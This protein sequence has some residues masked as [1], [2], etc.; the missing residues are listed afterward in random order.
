MYKN[1]GNKH[2][3]GLGVEGIPKEAPQ[4]YSCHFNQGVHWGQNWITSTHQRPALTFVIEVRNG[5]CVLCKLCGLLI[6]AFEKGSLRVVTYRQILI[7]QAPCFNFILTLKSSTTK[8]NLI[9]LIACLKFFQLNL[10]GPPHLTGGFGQHVCLQDR[11]PQPPALHRTAM[12][13]RVHTHQMC[14]NQQPTQCLHVCSNQQVTVQSVCSNQ[15]PA[16]LQQSSSLQQPASHQPCFDT[17]KLVQTL[18]PEK[19]I[20]KPLGRC[21]I[22][23]FTYNRR[24]LI[25]D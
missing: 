1:K 21:S 4:G 20:T 14:T 2:C 5:Q 24:R 10:Q 3:C 19:C 7:Q 22:Y 8:I 15:P 17:V 6:N 9:V 18:R 25:T 13:A 12:V 16:S 23:V 11:V